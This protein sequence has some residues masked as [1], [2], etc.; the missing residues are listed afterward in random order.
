MT[1]PRE[2]GST[3][4]QQI[5]FP[6][7]PGVLAAGARATGLPVAGR[8]AIDHP[9][10]GRPF[11]GS[12]DVE[13]GEIVP[14][15]DPNDVRLA[16]R[17]TGLLAVFN[18]AGVLEAADVHV[19]DRLGELGG[20]GDQTVRLAVALTVRALRG[21]SVCLA[22]SEIP[23]VATDLPWPDP[24]AWASAVRGSPLVQEGGPLRFEDDLLYLDR[25]AEQEEQV[26]ADLVARSAGPPPRF[27]PVLLRSGLDRLFTDPAGRQR[28]AA[29]AAV[30]GWTT[31]L[32]GGPGTGKTTTVA[33]ILALVLDQPG[34]PLRVALAAPT[35]KAAARLQEA[36]QDATRS[37]DPADRDRLAGLTASTVHRLLGYRPGSRTRFRHD[38]D[39]RLPH[40]IVVVDETSMVSLTLMARLLEAVRPDARLLLVGDPD[41]LASVE[42]G[43]VLADLVGGLTDEPAAGTRTDA[44]PG[45]GDGVGGDRAGGD[46]LGGDRVGT[47]DRDRS[48]TTGTAPGA[49]RP[50]RSAAGRVVILDHIWRF[51]G[52]VAELAAAVRRGD[53][54]TAV[55][56][57]EAGEGGVSFSDE[58]AAL[59]GIQRDVVAADRAIV[60]AA[61]DGDGAGAV[62]LLGRHRVLCA[63][64]AG[65][66]GVQ[67]WSRRIERWI[68]EATGSGPSAEWYAGRPLLVTAN[69]YALGLFNGDS[70]V[71]VRAADGELRAAFPRGD[72]TVQIAPSRLSEVQTMHALTVHRSQG[73]QFARVTLVLPPPE[74]PLLTRELLY[75]ALTRTEEHVR[76]V[77][78]ADA[79]RI[80]VGRPATRASGLR[81]R[82]RARA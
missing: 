28:E 19:A 73:S 38:R 59:P 47:M 26:C 58:L 17:A 21:G 79:V 45:A 46:G 60:A 8:V 78:T 16:R 53:A 11:A 25:Y 66:Y 72:G 30:T 5:L 23:A 55:A 69:D 18:R 75:T 68:E 71:T 74:S 80:A 12:G 3:A 57:L 9:T 37:F 39:N 65:P 33:R 76:V 35:G 56:L 24:A 10:T 64:R 20:E 1:A 43:A 77:G 29:E 27:D 40:D 14:V 31:V 4:A 22:L 49:G 42:A 82:L 36:V 81:Q 32:G 34:P 51:G 63:H 6:D 52:A 61:L 15:E 62:R 50:V 44:V 54:D 13:P 48:E 70:G 67:W 41:Q 7:A 2:P